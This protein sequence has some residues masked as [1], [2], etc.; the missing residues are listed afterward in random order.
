MQ[1]DRF[2]S[3]PLEF[4]QKLEDTP[5]PRGLLSNMG[6]SNSSN[7]GFV[8]HIALERLGTRVDLEILK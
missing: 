7:R 4:I 2:F 1:V 6:H 8:T 5:S 3:S